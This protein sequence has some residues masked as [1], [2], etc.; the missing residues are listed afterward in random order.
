[1]KK[2][3]NQCSAGNLVLLQHLEETGN[4]AR[5]VANPRL[6]IFQADLTSKFVYCRKILFYRVSSKERW[7]EEV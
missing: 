5:T 1:M 4:L 7:T 2:K 3:Y 6:T